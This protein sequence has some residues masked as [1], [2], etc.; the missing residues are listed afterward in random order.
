MG[1]SR[2][3]HLAPLPTNVRYAPNSDQ[4]IALQ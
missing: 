2:P 3:S 4:N 1:H